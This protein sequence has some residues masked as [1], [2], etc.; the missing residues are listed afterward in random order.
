MKN[1]I[2]IFGAAGSGTTTLGRKISE[3]YGYKHMDTDEY[4]WLP[5]EPRFTEKRTPEE[6]V[7][8]MIADIE[9]YD[10]VVISGA[11]TD[12][13]DELIPYFTLAI[14][15][16]ADTNIR[17]ERIKNREKTRF[18]ARI[19]P[20]GDMYQG[21]IDFLEWASMYDNGSIEIRSKA[22]HDAWQ[23]QLR[24]PLLQLDGSESL[25]K[26]FEKVKKILDKQNVK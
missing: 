11:L 21:H 4:Y 20:G 18:G 9:K 6:R 16:H 3:E 15:I 19:E 26:K 10:N 17:I 8:L 2:H 23:K 1:V 7:A 25:S 12:W 24:C 5:T 13:G 14:R 22:K